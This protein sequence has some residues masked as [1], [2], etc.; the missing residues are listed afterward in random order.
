M[1]FDFASPPPTVRNFVPPFA[2][3]APM[4]RNH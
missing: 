3:V 2:S 4:E 1:N